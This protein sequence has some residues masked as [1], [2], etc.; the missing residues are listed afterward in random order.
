MTSTVSSA[1]MSDMARRPETRS[2]NIAHKKG[3]LVAHRVGYARK[4]LV[5]VRDTHILGLPAVDTTPE[6][7]SSVGIGTV[8]HIAV[9]AEKA[10]ATE[11]FDIN[12]YAV[13]RLNRSDGAAY[14]L[15]RTDHLVADGY[16]LDG[17]GYASMLYMQVAG[18]D[19]SERDTHHGIARI[20]YDWQRAS[21]AARNARDRRMYRL[22]F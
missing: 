22:S 18:A 4:A 20:T 21:R 3:L 1:D 6:S 2:E 7:P 15:D 14:G 19:T 8:V 10:L 11:C 12:R 9:A 17:A 5:G 13:A 16:P